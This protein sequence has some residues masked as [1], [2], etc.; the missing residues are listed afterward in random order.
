MDSNFGRASYCI[1]ICHILRS[2]V[3]LVYSVYASL[4][5]KLMLKL[6]LRVTF[7]TISVSRFLVVKAFSK[8]ASK[9]CPYL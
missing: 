6:K 1:L 3:F 2:I 4:V 5:C 8:Y 9:R 7:G